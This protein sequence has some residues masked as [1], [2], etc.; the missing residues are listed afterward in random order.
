MRYPPKVEA[1]IA[2]VA[3]AA[4]APVAA[5]GGH[6]FWSAESDHVTYR[7]AA[8]KITTPLPHLA[9]PHQQANLALAIAM[10]RHQRALTIPADAYAAAA[11]HAT[12]P[13]RMQRLGPGPVTAKLPGRSI[14]VDG[15]HNADAARAIAAA[16]AGSAPIDLVFGL[17]K[18]RRIADV[19]G[20]LAPLVRTAHV[21]PLIGH[22]HHDPR[23]VAAFAQAHS[24]PR[25]CYPA[26]SL[27]QALDR[28]ADDAEGL[29]L[30][31]IAGSLY[32]AGEVLAANGELPD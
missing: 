22:E 31:L 19:L 13:A 3:R 25:H 29:P 11:E 21:V 9:G 23:D 6:W 12:W 1:R 10:L 5:E 17:M 30:I 14:I 24:A 26:A 16:L 4:G 18:N 20:T 28:L 8:G 7:D 15:G 32:L 2:G 27:E